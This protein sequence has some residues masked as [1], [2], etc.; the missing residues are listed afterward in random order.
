MTKTATVSDVNANSLNDAG[1]I[2]VYTITV[3]NKGNVTISTPTFN[4]YLIDGEGTN[5]TSSLVG[6]TY[7]SKTFSPTIK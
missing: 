1:D 3:E 7:T 2:I 6:P 5:L 4:E